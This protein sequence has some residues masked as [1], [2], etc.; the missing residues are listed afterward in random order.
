MANDNLPQYETISSHAESVRSIIQRLANSLDVN[1]LDEKSPTYKNL[2]NTITALGGGTEF[3]E[4]NKGKILRGVA[5]GFLDDAGKLE[6]QA[7]S[8][9]PKVNN[10]S[11]LMVLIKGVIEEVLNNFFARKGNKFRIPPN[12]GEEKYDSL[13]FSQL[14]LE[15]IKGGEITKDGNYAVRS[16]DIHSALSNKPLVKIVEQ[17]MGGTSYKILKDIKD[18]LVVQ[19][20]EPTGENLKLV[21]NNG[22][23]E[24]TIQPDSVR[25]DYTAIP[26]RT[27]KIHILCGSMN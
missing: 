6:L 22:K 26:S 13:D 10:D 7:V 4:K 11:T 9:K 2:N 19:I 1:E 17:S 21:N 8:K 18:A 24:I 25:I 3:E 20:Y 23:F 27:Y 14:K 12:E 15:N 16:S 5:W